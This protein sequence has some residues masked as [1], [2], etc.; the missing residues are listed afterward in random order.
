[1]GGS[2]HPDI[3]VP[4][5]SKRGKTNVQAEFS[6]PF[7]TSL[8]GSFPA[9]GSRDRLQHCS[10]AGR[11]AGFG[12]LLGLWWFLGMLL[13]LVSPIMPGCSSPV[14]TCSFCKG[15]STSHC[16]LQRCKLSDYNERWG[17]SSSL[18]GRPWHWR[19][20]LHSCAMNTSVIF[21]NHADMPFCLLKGPPVGP[22]AAWPLCQ[23][24]VRPGCLVYID[25]IGSQPKF[26]DV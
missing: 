25:A 5:C 11:C 22:R 1:M 4:R 24:Q 9:A 23:A 21:V 13:D 7:Q 17:W 15:C 3:T 2:G 26:E 20:Y 6:F 18:Y 16:Q 14:F 8:P 12:Y 10:C 19:G